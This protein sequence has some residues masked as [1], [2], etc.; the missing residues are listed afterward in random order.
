MR[1]LIPILLFTITTT[2]VFGQGEIT[3]GSFEHDDVY[4]NVVM[5]SLQDIGVNPKKDNY[6]KLVSL[7]EKRRLTVFPV[8]STMLESITK[9]V[10]LD[11]DRRKF[12][13][14][15]ATAPYSKYG[16]NGYYIPMAVS[17]TDGNKLEW[18]YE[19]VGYFDIEY[20][21][22]GPFPPLN[23]ITILGYSSIDDG[24]TPYDWV[25]LREIGKEAS[26]P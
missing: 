11:P 14:F 15:I 13:A 5:T 26:Q 22:D 17:T 19:Q 10:T 23:D 12:N 18:N 6:V 21:P 25:F 20:M 3:I 7:A 9:M 8:D 1:K 4:Y 24:F 16:N 2:L